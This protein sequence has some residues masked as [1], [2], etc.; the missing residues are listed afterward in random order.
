MSIRSRKRQKII[1]AM[2][3]CMQH[4]DTERRRRKQRRQNQ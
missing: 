4:S 1:K 2:M 3:R